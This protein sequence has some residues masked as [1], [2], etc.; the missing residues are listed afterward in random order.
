MASVL[1]NY[2]NLVQ[3]SIIFR[4]SRDFIHVFQETSLPT[5][6]ERL[7]FSFASAYILIVPLKSLVSQPFCSC[8]GLSQKFDR[9]KWIMMAY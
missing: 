1:L 4:L 7:S 8:G 3:K 2:L 6:N 9:K 5:G